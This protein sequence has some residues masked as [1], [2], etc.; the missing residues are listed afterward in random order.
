MM[1]K[2]EDALLQCSIELPDVPVSDT[3]KDASSNPVDYI[4]INCI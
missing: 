2:D 4:I 1:T 3:T